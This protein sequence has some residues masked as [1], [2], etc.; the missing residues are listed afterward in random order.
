MEIDLS[1]EDFLNSPAREEIDEY[2]DLSKED[3][4][5][6]LSSQNGIYAW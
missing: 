2:C 4:E 6:I 3:V 5:N 1:S